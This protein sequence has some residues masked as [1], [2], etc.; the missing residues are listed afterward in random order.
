MSSFEF[1]VDSWEY[2]GMGLWGDGERMDILAV[3]DLEEKALKRHLVSIKQLQAQILS[4]RSQLEAH[5]DDLEMCWQSIL[6]SN[7]ITGDFRSAIDKKIGELRFDFLDDIPTH[8][9]RLKNG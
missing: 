2:K 3:S 8:S 6:R 9:L 4:L 5:L 1:S 7:G